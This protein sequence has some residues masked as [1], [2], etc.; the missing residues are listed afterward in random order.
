MP[1]SL[2]TYQT[3]AAVL[4]GKNGSG[5]RLFGWTIARTLLIAP[6]IMAVGVSPKRA[7]LGAALASSL[8]SVF[9]LARIY[10]AGFIERQRKLGARRG[11]DS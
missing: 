7:F 11:G 2:P 5:I 9:T 10:N 1:A 8:I 3:V 6:P 4:E